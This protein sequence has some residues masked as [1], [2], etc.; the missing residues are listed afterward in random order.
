MDLTGGWVWLWNV[1]NQYG[2]SSGGDLATIAQKIKSN[3][4]R[5]VIVKVADGNGVYPQ[6]PLLSPAQVVVEL[7]SY[8]IDVATWSY[9]YGDAMGE[10][11]AVTRAL[12]GCTPSFHVLDVEAQVEQATDPVGWAN[13]IVSDINVARPD[14]PLVYAPLPIIHYHTRLPYY[15]LSV[16]HALPMIPQLYYVGLQMTPLD[17]VTSFVSDMEQYG[18]NGPTILPSYEDSPLAKPNQGSSDVDAAAFTTLCLQQGWGGIVVWV[19][20]YMDDA[21]WARFSAACAVFTPVPTPTPVPVPTPPSTSTRMTYAQIGA[22][23][24]ATALDDN[25]SDLDAQGVFNAA[26]TDIYYLTWPASTFN[27]SSQKEGPRDG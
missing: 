3:G 11:A 1:D 18:L 4:G 26:A 7:Q 8:G 5:G 15:Q 19:Y 12:V 25:I 17:T 21:A 22:E 2:S 10:A 27:P 16:G 9:H 23:L 24:V 20:E 13:G 6:H 14:I